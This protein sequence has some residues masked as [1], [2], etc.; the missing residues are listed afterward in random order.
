[1]EIKLAAHLHFSLLGKNFSPYKQWSQC[2]QKRLVLTN[3]LLTL[4]SIRLK[5]AAE[6]AKK[7]RNTLTI[8]IN[9]IFA[10]FILFFSFH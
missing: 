10:Q 6:I 3:I 7:A 8:D 2:N 9:Q 5:L 4:L 1:M